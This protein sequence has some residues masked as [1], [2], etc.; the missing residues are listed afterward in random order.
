MPLPKPALALKSGKGAILRKVKIVKEDDIDAL[1]APP[2]VQVDI[3][4]Q[5]LVMKDE[6]G[7]KEL[8]ATLANLLG[9]VDSCFA[10]YGQKGTV[11]IKVH[12]DGKGRV[13]RVEILNE[14]KWKDTPAFISCLKINLMRSLRLP[15]EAGGHL[16]FT[17]TT[18]SIK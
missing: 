16:V 6:V 15:W 8:K 2:K 18:R 11:K 10:D 12:F 13:D 17:V 14:K 4:E 1:Q 9:D 5:K 3:K 7:N